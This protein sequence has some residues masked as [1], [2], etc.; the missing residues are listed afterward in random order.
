M[1]EFQVTSGGARVSAQ[2]PNLLSITRDQSP[3]ELIE[4]MIGAKH[5]EGHGLLLDYR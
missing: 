1:P 2:D 3:L 5:P 4:R